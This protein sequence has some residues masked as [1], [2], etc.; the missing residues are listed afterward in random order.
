[1]E[2][3]E[4]AIDPLEIV[5]TELFP[6]REYLDPAIVRSNREKYVKARVYLGDRWICAFK[7]TKYKNV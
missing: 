6:Y 4:H 2:N 5:A 7:R 3:I 1:M